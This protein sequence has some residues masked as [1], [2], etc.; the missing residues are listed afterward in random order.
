MLLLV[1]AL[2]VVVSLGVVI[3]V[4]GCVEFLPLKTVDDEVGGVT[5]L[6]TTPRRSRIHH[7]QTRIRT[8]YGN[9]RT[10]KGHHTFMDIS[11]NI[12]CT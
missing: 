11:P 7:G 1:V 2:A 8:S 6:E 5:A 10:N 3:L 12:W 9:Q 4:A